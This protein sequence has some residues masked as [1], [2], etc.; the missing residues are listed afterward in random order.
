MRVDIGPVIKLASK[1]TLVLAS[2]GLTDNL[3]VSDIV[4]QVRKGTIVDAGTK[5]FDSVLE[6]MS[7]PSGS[8]DDVAT[9]LFRLASY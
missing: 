7:I 4:E 6:S 9:V 1:D 2:D 3:G 8:V 5:L